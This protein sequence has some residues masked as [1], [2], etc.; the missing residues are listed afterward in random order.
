MAPWP[1]SINHF[2][3]LSLSHSIWNC[4]TNIGTSQCIIFCNIFC[5]GSG[6]TH[7]ACPFHSYRIC[8]MCK[9]NVR[10][11]SACNTHPHNHG[12]RGI[13]IEYVLETKDTVELEKIFHIINECFNSQL[14]S[15]SQVIAWSFF[16]FYL[17]LKSGS[18]INLILA[19]VLLLQTGVSVDC[20]SQV[21]SDNTNAG[22]FHSVD[23]T[24]KFDSDCAAII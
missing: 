8:L 22:S 7:F 2:L 23:T 4:N 5:Q 19:F 24:A 6:F 21:F 11:V 18:C 10:P 16:C 20:T 14:A 3:S 12:K 13:I 17:M 9:V 1:F 15:C